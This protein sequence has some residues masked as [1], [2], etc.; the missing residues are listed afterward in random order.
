MEILLQ[1]LIKT[2]I[3]EEMLSQYLPLAYHKLRAGE[4]DNSP[5][6]ILKGHVRHVLASY[7]IAAGTRP[8]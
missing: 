4:I 5:A 7:G 2:G 6:A 8:L 1:N 3:P